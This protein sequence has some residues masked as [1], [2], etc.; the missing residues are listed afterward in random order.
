MPDVGGVKPPTV[1]GSPLFG[2]ADAHAGFGHAD[3]VFAEY[4]PDWLDKAAHVGVDF[5]LFDYIRPADI[6]PS[7]NARPALTPAST[8][9]MSYASSSF[10][11]PQDRAYALDATLQS[12]LGDS[13]L[14]L[15]SH[16]VSPALSTDEWS[17]EYATLD[18]GS[19]DFDYSGSGTS[20]LLFDNLGLGL[21]GPPV[22]ATTSSSSSYGFDPTY[23]YATFAPVTSSGL[24]S[25]NFVA[26]PPHRSTN[27]VETRFS[28]VMSQGTYENLFAESL[29]AIPSVPTA[30]LSIDPQHRQHAE[31]DDFIHVKT[32]P[33]PTSL[34]D[35]S[36]L[37]PVVDEDPN[38]AEYVPDTK[39]KST[40]TMTTRRTRPS[41]SSAASESTSPVPP[42]STNA[43]TTTLAT[44][45]R[46][47]GTAPPIL[48]LDAPIQERK[49]R[50]TSRTS[51]KAVPK[52]LLVQRERAIARGDADVASVEELADEADRRR[53]ANTLSARESRKRKKDE[54]DAQAR[55]NGEL[56]KEN[57]ALRNEVEELR[58]DNGQLRERL[59][60]AEG[61]KAEDEKRGTKRAR[62]T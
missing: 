8:S 39:V 23:R 11:K 35:L 15:P 43:T 5:N 59:R 54:I 28:P 21:E 32:E 4:E 6:E 16:S 62:R 25:S 18:P 49:Y 57:D 7:P 50:V 26:P 3:G 36:S 33:L 58:R 38:D 52:A 10:A 44:L 55:E 53:R 22:T 47:R 27:E 14:L 42:T 40:R 45:T 56:R 30:P 60:V 17:P 9:S 29:P 31:E 48:P 51:R 24:A 34:A 13:P 20:P 12:P 61:I 2:M 19:S 46:R 41:L 1:P 37:S